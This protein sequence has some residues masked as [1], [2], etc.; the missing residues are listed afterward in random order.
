MSIVFWGI[1][2]AMIGVALLLVLPPLFGRRGR[3]HR[4]RDDVNLAIHRQRLDELERD[5]ADGAIDRSAYDEARLEI[6]HGLLEEVPA[7]PPAGPPP[8]RGGRVAAIVVGLAVPIVAVTLYLRVGAPNEF[9]GGSSAATST[10]G[11]PSASQIVAMLEAETNAH[12][13]DATAWLMLARAYAVLGRL[14]DARTAYQ[15][16][17][18]F[19]PRD[20]DVLLGYAEV[21]ARLD[22]NSLR[23]RPTELVQE[24]VKI[25]P[26]APKALWLAGIA[27]YQAGDRA[28]ALAYWNKL[29]KLGP[30]PKDEEALLDRFIASAREL[31]TGQTDAGQSDVGQGDTGSPAGPVS[32]P[33][34]EVH[35]A[36]DPAVA[37][38]VDPDA[39]VFVFARA[40]QGPRMP[41]AVVRK[42]VRDLPF[43]VT[44][45]DSDAMVA[46]MNLS[47]FR[48]VVVGARVSR[49][50]DA[51]P[52]P[53]DF[54]ALSPAVSTTADQVIR[55]NIGKPAQAAT[56]SS[57]RVRVHVALAPDLAKQARPDETV[58]VFAR[59]AQGPPMPLAVVTKK[60]RDLPF[61]VTLD[62]S[63]AM[64]PSMNLSRF[65]KVVIGA[66]IAK[67]GSATPK[68]GDIQGLSPVV[69]PDSDPDVRISLA[70]V[71]H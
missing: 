35:V 16:A 3:T 17:Y 8:R 33:R 58:F 51:T 54:E 69:S 29:R 15:H 4:E 55:I 5:L 42:S 41:L 14:Q 20:P 23:G 47:G 22:G 70:D 24:A 36:L 32:G 19:R 1:A 31:P 53:G 13:Q 43:T 27:A 48:Q 21:L 12:P 6:E 37:K 26:Q 62:D 71:V 30:M 61:T 50:G 39:T 7:A 44:L 64:V 68:P 56:T 18:R 45:D 60:V 38:K 57:A 2:A 63:D 40:V 59:A 67:S 66:R 28:Q 52:A 34:L 65:D 9:S 46:D 10:A 11:Q 49:T 25:A